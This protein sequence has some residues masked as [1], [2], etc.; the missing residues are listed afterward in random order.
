LNLGFKDQRLRELGFRDL[1]FR[2]LGLENLGLKKPGAS[3][4]RNEMKKP[5]D[6][7]GGLFCLC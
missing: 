3:E 6:F 4:I 7:I 5:A 2:D 1:G